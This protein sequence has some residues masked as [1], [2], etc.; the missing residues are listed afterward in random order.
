MI[1]D[2][3]ARLSRRTRITSMQSTVGLSP[4]TCAAVGA[5]LSYLRLDVGGSKVLELG[6]G[7]GEALCVLRSLG[8]SCSFVE[9]HPGL[10]TLNRIRGFAGYLGDFLRRSL[11]PADITYIRGS[12][13][14]EYFTDERHAGEWLTAL[15]GMVI[16]SPW[17]PGRLRLDA[18]TAQET[19]L[20]RAA[21]DAG[22]E[23]VA[24]P[25]YNE[26][27]IYPITFVRGGPAAASMRT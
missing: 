5:L 19:L 15:P 26:A 21:L 11:P 20:G 6:P 14:D 3:V 23:S 25:I 24:A 9:R 22:F 18:E 7:R 12:V 8:A 4:A 1:S 27:T 16:L 10:Y 17:W 2:K 13:T